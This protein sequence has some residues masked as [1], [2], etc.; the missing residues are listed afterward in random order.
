CRAIQRVGEVVVRRARRVIA[1][2]KEAAVR[3]RDV[4]GGELKRRGV[5]QNDALACVSAG[6]NADAAIGTL[7][8]YAEVA[9]G[10]CAL[11]EVENVGVRIERDR[12]SI[13]K[14]TE[15]ANG[16]DLPRTG[17]GSEKGAPVESAPRRE[18]ARGDGDCRG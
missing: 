10:D 16:H 14:R 6:E 13:A 11:I 4:R 18:L 8:C 1:E 15:V 7:D 5:L 9:G 17:K 12:L 3:E 2:E